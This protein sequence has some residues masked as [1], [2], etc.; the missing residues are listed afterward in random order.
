MG[1]MPVMSEWVQA[2]TSILLSK[3]YC[4][5]SFSSSDKRELTYVCLSYSPRSIDS[6]GSIAN[7]SMSSL[8]TRAANCDC[9]YGG[10][11]SVARLLGLVP[12]SCSRTNS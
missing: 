6:K 9:Y 3:T 12:F 11:D 8:S 10:Y 5:C 2:N 1:L 4:N 7:C